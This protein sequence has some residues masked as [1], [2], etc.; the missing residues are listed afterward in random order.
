M[1]R[2]STCIL[3]TA[4]V[5]AACDTEAGDPLSLQATG[6]VRGSAYID[7]NGNFERDAADASLANLRVRLYVRNSQDTLASRITDSSG[8]FTFQAVPVGEYDLRIDA[9]TLPDTLQIGL[10]DSNPIRVVATDTPR[11]TIAAGFPVASIADARLEVPG[12]RI[13]IDA[14]ALNHRDTYP[15]GSVFVSDGTGF[16]RLTSLRSGQL[17]RGNRA[18]FLGVLTR[19]DN[20]PTLNDVTFF[21]TDSVQTPPPIGVSTRDAAS[22]DGG[23]LDAALVSVSRATVTSTQ[24]SGNEYRF[25]VDD[26]SGALETIVSIDRGFELGL[27]VPGT[28]LDLTGLL[29]PTSSPTRWVLRPRNAA[30]IT[31]GFP[32]VTVAEARTLEA[33]TRVIILGTA[34]NRRDAFPDITVHIA[35]ATGAIRGTG[36]GPGTILAGDRARFLGVVSSRDG[37]PTLDQITAFILDIGPLPSPTPLTTGVAA[38]ASNGVFDAAHVQVRQATITDT[39]TVGE[40]LRIGVDDGTGRIEVAARKSGDFNFTNYGIG[41]VLD[42]T[43]VLVP[44]PG[45]GRWHLRARQDADIRVNPVQQ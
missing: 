28:E 19:R 6:E 9:A 14:V 39:A 22:A 29:V 34:L 38:T 20:Q 5:L 25:T 17:L 24:V 45:E 30:D 41:R 31:L 21:V 32:T 2:I 16:I 35:D 36:V 23:D 42:A 26:G 40:F 1:K 7:V 4:A 15:D 10:I 18:K 8:S 44:V 33:G 3:L 13:F 37:Q 27:L 43:G 11:V 12:G